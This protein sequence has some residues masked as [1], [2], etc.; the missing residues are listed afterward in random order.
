M[1]SH[2]ELTYINKSM[3]NDLSTIFVFTKN[4]TPTFDALKDGVAGNA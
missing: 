1:A 2:I 4:E 3:N